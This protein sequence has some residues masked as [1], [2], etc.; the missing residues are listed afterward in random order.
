MT[1][2]IHQRIAA[3]RRRDADNVLV[4]T[5]ATVLAAA[6]GSTAFDPDV[7]DTPGRVADRDNWRRWTRIVLDA[8]GVTQLTRDLRIAR[9]RAQLAGRHAD[10]MDREV[11]E[12]DATLANRQ[13]TIAGL[14]AKDAARQVELR[15]LRAELDTA[16]EL[17]GEQ[18]GPE[19]DGVS[20]A[21]A[22]RQAETFHA[23]MMRWACAHNARRSE[24]EEA[25]DALRRLV[26]A[27]E[28][29]PEPTSAVMDA[30]G[31][32]RDVLATRV[33]RRPAAGDRVEDGGQLGT[34]V[35]CETC[36]GDG[37]LHQLD[38]PPPPGPAPQPEP[39]DEPTGARR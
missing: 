1:D 6:S 35:T 33:P 30:V 23:E 7:Q 28:E 31:E 34:L 25:R 39:A 37:L 19:W 15:D 10:Q 26:D 12:L 24:R 17:V 13:A 18:A 9:A 29:Q 5:A 22:I 3:A 21:E 11:A 8:A 16:R 36:S 20:R 38:E 27:V 4:E 32:A 2:S 14:T